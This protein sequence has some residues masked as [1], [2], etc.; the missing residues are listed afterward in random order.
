MDTI[1][2]LR[3]EI[4]ALRR[5]VYLD[6]LTELGNRRLLEERTSGRGGYFV[7]I[8]LN[9]FK[10]VNDLLGHAYGDDV[11]RN[12]ARHL[13]VHAGVGDRVACRVGGDEFT[14]WCPSRESA[15]VMLRKVWAWSCAGVTASAGIGA[16]KELA[17]ARARENKRNKR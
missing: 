11:L 16:T 14:V 15:E 7:A 4:A 12:F 13:L 1:E 5:D 6:P 3:A 2:A 10:R 17:D 8:D 9:D